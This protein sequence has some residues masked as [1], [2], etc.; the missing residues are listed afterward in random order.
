[1]KEI[2]LTFASATGAI[3]IMTVLAYMVFK[4]LEDN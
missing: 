1:M 2:L 3:I 4:L